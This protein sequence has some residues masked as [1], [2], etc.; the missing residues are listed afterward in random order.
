MKS[1]V[2]PPLYPD[3]VRRQGMNGVLRGLARFVQAYGFWP[4]PSEL[5][6]AMKV[7]AYAAQWYLDELAEER[8]T[9]RL[10]THGMRGA[11]AITGGG[12]RA[13]GLKPIA[14]YMPRPSARKKARLVAEIAAEVMREIGHAD[15][16][17]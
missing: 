8:L 17:G 3:R 2:A 1:K 13:L 9:E 12:W 6:V 16:D 4:R 15:G 14:P 10:R 5:A 7:T 11:Y